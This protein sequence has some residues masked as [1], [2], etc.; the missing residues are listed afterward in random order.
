[1]KSKIFI[2][3]INEINQFK[4][5]LKSLNNPEIT[6]FPNTTVIHGVGGM[7]KSTLCRKFKE[8]CQTDY[9]S[10]NCIFLNWD[11]YSGSTYSPS[12]LLNSI[13]FKLREIF[14][15]ENAIFF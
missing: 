12:E 2:G 7:G 14:P 15:D 13:S 3:R 6:I 10:L 4:A 11:D 8:I 9:P 5:K 1:M